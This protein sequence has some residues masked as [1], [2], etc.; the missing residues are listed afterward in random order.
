MRNGQL[1]ATLEALDRTIAERSGS[2]AALEADMKK[3]NTEIE[4]KTREMD[5]LNR[6]LQKLTEGSQGAETGA[7]QGAGGQ[8]DGERIGGQ[9]DMWCIGCAAVLLRSVV[10]AE[11]GFRAEKSLDQP[12]VRGSATSLPTPP[13]T[14]SCLTKL[15]HHSPPAACRPPGGHHPQPAARDWRQDQGGAGAAAALD[16]SAGAAGGAAVRER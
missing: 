6:K 2:I 1:A 3:R 12:T 14:P 4:Q 10:M 5:V 15:L 16:R 13:P 7:L 11:G 8:A 9:H